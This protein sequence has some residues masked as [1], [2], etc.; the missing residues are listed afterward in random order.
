MNEKGR[1]TKLLAAIAI[2]AMVVCAIAVVMPSG[3]VD[4]VDDSTSAYEARIGDV[5]YSTFEAA[6]DAAVDGDTIEILANLNVD[7]F[8]TITNKTITIDLNGFTITGTAT[9]DGTEIPQGYVLKTASGADVIINGPGKI[10]NSYT[11]PSDAE[12]PI[13]NKAYGI[14]LAG[15]DSTLTLNNVTVDAKQYGITATGY[16]TAGKNA[17][18][19]DLRDETIT[20]DTVFPTHLYINNSTINSPYGAVSTNGN[21]GFEYIE[22]NNSTL[23][24]SEGIAIYIP[25]NAKVIVN[26]TT[27]KSS[28]GIDQRTGYLE[29]NNSSITYTGEGQ[30]KEAGD[31]P[32]DFGVGI[33]IIDA[34]DYS[35][36]DAVTI[37][38]N[39][40]FTGNEDGSGDIVMGVSRDN[41]AS[42]DVGGI[43]S[44]TSTAN[45]NGF[46]S[47]DGMEFSTKTGDEIGVSYTDDGSVTVGMANTL[48]VTEDVTI[49]EGKT[50]TIGKGAN[51]VVASGNNLDLDNA[52]VKT[53]ADNTWTLAVGAGS[54]VALPAET[55]LPTAGDNVTVV[56]DDSEVTVGGVK[57]DITASTEP[58]NITTQEDLEEALELGYSTIDIT[59]EV[60]ITQDIDMGSVA[61]KATG[62][63]FLDVAE[64]VTVTFTGG[65]YVGKVTGNGVS[66]DVNLYGTFTIT[67]GSL[68]IGDITYSGDKDITITIDDDDIDGTNNMIVITGVLNA[69]VTIKSGLIN[70]DVI[71]D[72]RNLNI[73]SAGKLNFEGFTAENSSIRANE[74][75]SVYGQIM[76]DNN[77]IITA[78]ANTTFRAYGGSVLQDTVSVESYNVNDKTTIINLDGAMY[79]LTINDDINSSNVYGQTQTVVIGSTLDI[80]SGTT[81]KI[82][83]QFVVNEGVTLT[84]QN[85]ATLI[86]DGPTSVMD[87]NGNIIVEDGGTLEVRNSQAVD[88]AGSID[89][90]G[91]MSVGANGIV[92][93]QEN[94]NVTVAVGGEL[95]VAAGTTVKAGATVDI[96]GKFEISAIEN[97]GTINLTG[98]VM[99]GASIITLDDGGVVNV[100]SFTVGKTNSQG[101]ATSNVTLTIQDKA[102]TANAIRFG[103][104]DITDETGFSGTVVTAEKTGTTEK[105]VYTL[106]VSGSIAGVDS[107]VAQN[108]DTFEASVSGTGVAVAGDLTLGEGVTLTV[109]GS[110]KLTVG[111]TVT[112]TASKSKIT[113]NGTIDV[114]GTVTVLS[115][116]ALGGTVNAAYYSLAVTGTTTPTTVYTTFED[117]VQSGATRVTV[118]V[119]TGSVVTVRES[120]TVPG[121]VTNVTVT[122]TMNVGATDNRDITVTVRDGSRVTGKIV[123]RATMTFENSRNDNASVISDVV[124]N[125]SP[126]RTYTNLYTA[127][128]SGAETVTLAGPVTLTS[129]ITVPEGTTLVVPAGTGVQFN[130][131]VTMTVN[132]AVQTAVDFTCLDD[133]DGNTVTFTDKSASTTD[134]TAKIVVNGKSMSS[135]TGRT[136]AGMYGL[137]KIPGAYYDI[138][139]STGAFTVIAPVAAAAAEAAADIV[140][141]SIVVYGEVSMGDVAFNG[142]ADDDLIIDILGKSTG[143]VTLSYATLDID[144]Q[145]TGSVSTAVGSIDL[146]NVTGIEVQDAYV[147][148]D[149]S[150]VEYMYLTGTPAPVDADVDASLTVAS[151]NVTVRAVDS[152]NALTIVETQVTENNETVTVS[153]V[154][155]EVAS[156]ATLT[157]NGAVDVYDVTVNGT[158]TAVDG[159][160]L[161]A[162]YAYVFGTLTVAETDTAAKIGAGSA[163]ITT[164][165]V[166]LDRKYDNMTAATVDG[167]VGNV[168]LMVVSAESTVSEGLLDDFSASTAFNVEG[169]VWFTAYAS[170]NSVP[171]T[172]DDVKVENALFIGWSDEENG[173]AIEAANSTPEDVVYQTT[174][175]VGQY[176]TLYAVVDY[177]IYTVTIT[178]DAGIGTVA[179]DG[180][181][182]MKSDNVFIITGLTAGSHTIDYILNSGFEGTPTI[183][184]NGTAITGNT[185]TLSGTDDLTVEISI[186]GTQPAAPSQGGSTASGDDGLGLTDY[187]LIILVILIVIMA[188][189]VAMRLM[190]S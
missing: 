182:L 8:I 51:I 126:A 54:T 157:V 143:N 97:A 114:T 118:G 68:I 142:T 180:K 16:V 15:T 71:I 133:D 86:I 85:G 34:E 47:I 172:V 134:N 99:N 162:D 127:L 25:S 96:L 76:S 115:G 147:E 146:V 148:V 178:A 165:Y 49:G 135:V 35:T 66:A 185:F 184:V 23:N 175:N 119:G 5:S 128:A 73:T 4:A 32:T 91:T 82:Q 166:G 24:C 109:S 153:S 176:N 181:V 155:F 20:E 30:N 1:Q 13:V 92:T 129:N 56:G 159:G 10:T 190:R 188:I 74:T 163:E 21:N 112:A 164:L 6:V 186:Y 52:N 48:T 145:F 137:Y 18:H 98:A 110:A 17:T 79:T 139:D 160:R 28:S 131:G 116:A 141:G 65:S 29:V 37:V 19:T 138:S 152:G 132:G 77:I 167:Q 174:F 78:Q 108:N 9:Y 156:G 42:T 93:V 26:N 136:D 102:G 57:Q 40:T 41:S 123:V 161:V 55:T 171:V 104:T 45:R 117:A 106:Y 101:S 120:V 60:E 80:V 63:G 3:Q 58:D 84:I 168:R 88:I 38:N 140:D 72:L 187:L 144:A 11:I 12:D 95:V 90:Y 14:L 124:I 169:S 122:G 130:E 87:V 75:V 150:D 43:L 154:A 81:I 170:G 22:I 62:D 189:I 27:I 64:G 103:N 89:I 111:G 50:F 173:D 177:E 94:G 44:S 53:P 7:E 2:I 149:G 83:G 67:G 121:T 69:N 113:N 158:V 151:G 59:S 105:P 36:A 46:L 100:N 70:D 39:V 125:E 31:G 183:T 179:V 61:I 33:S 107:S